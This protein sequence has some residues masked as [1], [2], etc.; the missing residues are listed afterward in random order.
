MENLRLQ[1]AIGSSFVD[2]LVTL[3]EAVRAG[4]QRVPFRYR[5]TPQSPIERQIG[6][7]ARLALSSE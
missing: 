7:A 2:E 6:E 5:S 3:V 1:G 4:G